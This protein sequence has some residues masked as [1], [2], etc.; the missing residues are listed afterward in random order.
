MFSFNITTQNTLTNS[1]SSS[2]YTSQFRYQPPFDSDVD[3]QAP[4]HPTTPLPSSIED[5]ETEVRV[6][7]SLSS[8]L[9]INP[10]TLW[11][12]YPLMSKDV[13]TRSKVSNLGL[14]KTIK[15]G[16]AITMIG[17]EG[18]YH[19]N[20]FFTVS[21]CTPPYQVIRVIATASLGFI[22]KHIGF[23]VPYEWV[24]PYS[25]LPYHSCY[26]F[27]PVEELFLTPPCLYPEDRFYSFF[28]APTPL[29]TPLINKVLR[30]IRSYAIRMLKGKNQSLAEEKCL[31]EELRKFQNHSVVGW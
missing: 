5:L 24:Q 14:P 26:V 12:Q 6:Y 13:S 8:Q 11:P 2:S 27:I 21:H 16:D 30:K 19:I 18:R 7:Q 29:P 31:E 1:N 9:P 15:Y 20:H 17:F 25:S 22:F 23:D 10:D 28:P 3:D 4:T